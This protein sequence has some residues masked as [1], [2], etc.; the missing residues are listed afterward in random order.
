MTK[1][2]QEELESLRKIQGDLM[3]AKITLGEME[4]EKQDLLRQISF[5]RQRLSDDE[6]AL[7]G[8]YGQDAVIN[9]STGEVTHKNK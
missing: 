8:K 5:L 6:R 2:T 3:K 7:I 1:L 9:M 4:L